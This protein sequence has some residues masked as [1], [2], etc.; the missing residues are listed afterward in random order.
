MKKSKLVALLLAA[1]MCVGLL[2][3]CGSSSS[4]TS[5][6]ASASEAAE[7][8]EETEETEAEAPAAEEAEAPAANVVALDS[9]EEGTAGQTVAVTVADPNEAMAEEYISYPLEGED[10][11]ISMWY[12]IPGY[13]E[14]MDSN[15][16]YNAISAAEEA[17]GVKIEF[18][19]VSDQSA[20]E[21]FNLMV[22]GGDIPDLI[23]AME[24][25]TGGISKAYEEGI[26]VDIGEYIDEY[27]PNYAA[28]LDCLAP[29]TV[30]A[31]LTDGMTLV[32][33]QI[34]DGTYSGN[35]MITRADWI[36]EQGWEWSGDLISLDEFT[37][38]LETMKDAY[39]VPYSIYMYDGTVGLE[40][41]FDTEIPALVGDGF[42]TVINS[43]IFRYGDEV[44]SGWITDGYREYLEWVLEMMDEG[45]IAKDYLSLDTD[46]GV[47]NTKQAAGEITVWQANADKMEEV[48]DTYGAD[49]PGLAVTAMPRVTAD[50]DAQYVW[51]DEA[52]LVSTSSG[53]SLSANCQNPELV[54]QWENYW[55][56][57]EGNVM[58]N[59]GIE[60]ESYH[61]DGDTPVFDWDQPTT[62]T[63]KNAPNAEMAQQL[64]TMLRFAGMYVDND[65]LLS[66]FPDSALAA[67]DLWTIDG[68]TDDRNYP[69]AAKNSFT[70]DEAL[71]IAEYE[72]DLL[73]YADE[74]CM[75]FLDGSLE[76]NDENWDEYVSTCEDMGINEIIA[77]YQTAYDEYKAGER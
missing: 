52:A 25:Y 16:N 23:P 71:E 11:T 3:A 68:S 47:V 4:D 24:Y 72:S 38:Y 26:I 60:G 33:Y 8:T 69:S 37:T 9:S 42:M 74:T 7:E 51:N 53:F 35:G 2:S 6:A 63:G 1:C 46:R 55:W 5:A 13:Q 32:F 43:A 27:M 10:N 14:Y 44:T 54:C 36:E 45:I 59:Y 15:Y 61:M 56:T 39:D 66:T 73:T 29:E 70:T 31:T 30:Q 20:N 77:I 19:E 50:P 22:A 17:T 12:Y 21:L 28:V 18:T 76:L 75:K 48:V 34:K 40:A 49:Y 65:M 62:V 57:T 67:V 41:A 58:G 64:F